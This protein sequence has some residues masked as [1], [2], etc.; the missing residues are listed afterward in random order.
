MLLLLL[1]WRRRRS[2]RRESSKSYNLDDLGSYG[3]HRYF[4]IGS[5]TARAVLS[6]GALKSRL[7]DPP[8]PKLSPALAQFY[9]L[10]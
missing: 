5:L 6:Q 2:G 9:E 7:F 4:V 3:V 1:L 8:N 10:L